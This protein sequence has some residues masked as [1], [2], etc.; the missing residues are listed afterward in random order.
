MQDC[1]FCKI[2]KKEIPSEIVYEDENFIV[3][4]DI[5]PFGPVALLILPKEHI[6]T[7]LDLAERE[8]VIAD[9]FSIAL[10]IAKRFGLDKKG[11]SFHVNGGGLQE[12]NHLHLKLGGGWENSDAEGYPKW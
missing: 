3:I 5:N 1:I 9:L 6:E 12:V 7:I 2:I 8:E 10:K 11:F 4:N